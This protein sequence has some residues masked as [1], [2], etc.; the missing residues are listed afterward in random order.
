MFQF[1][2]VWH[3]FQ[4]HPPVEVDEYFEAG[5]V[6]L[7]FLLTG[8]LVWFLVNHLRR[9]EIGLA[10]NLTEL[11]KAR[12]RLVQEEKLAA[13]GGCQRRLPTRSAIPSP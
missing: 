7:L 9:K 3:F 11:A 8:V 2:V 13:L 10:E 6:S 1:Y 5:T 4:L 12:E